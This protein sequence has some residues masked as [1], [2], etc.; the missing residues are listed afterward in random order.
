MSRQH[1]PVIGI[2]LT[3]SAYFFMALFSAL[4]K[5]VQEAGFTAAQVMFFDGLVGV[6][7]MA[8]V[9]YFKGGLRGLRMKNAKLQIFLMAVNVAGA[10]L[11]FQAYPYLALV[12]AYLIAF[13]GPLLIT[14]LSALILHERILLK[15]VVAMLFGFAGVVVA[16]GPLSIM[17]N[18]HV[19]KMFAGIALFA[20]SQVLVRKLSE[21]ESTW[22]FP[23]YYYL[24]MLCL[25]GALFHNEFIMPDTPR[26]WGMLLGLGIIDA[27]SLIMVYL[28]LKYAKASTVA[29]FQY[30]CLLWVVLLDMVLWNK[31]PPYYTWAGAAIV[32]LS[33]I[34][35]ATYGRKMTKH[36]KDG[37]A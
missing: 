31:F 34:Y 14:A 33:G 12:Q 26:Q 16:L 1:V 2:L 7:C 30:S 35:L 11:T 17:L 20:L 28:G 8:T 27:A 10:F 4:N 25:S 36:H 22:S 13:M 23:F 5:S 37:K 19:A 32:V 15:Q 24:G 9:A 6:L 21:T 18:E 29:P 3:I